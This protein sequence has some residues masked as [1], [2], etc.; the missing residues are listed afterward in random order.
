MIIRPIKETEYQY[1]YDFTQ[2]A[3]STAFVSDGNE[4]DYASAVRASAQYIKE[5]EYVAEEDGR[6]VGDVIFS[7]FKTDVGCNALMLNIV[8]VELGYRNRGLGQSLIQVA[9]AKAI[10][11][12]YEAVF[13]AGSPKFYNRLGFKQTTDFG[14]FNSNNYDDQYIL[15]KE[16]KKDALKD[17]NG[18]F[19]FA[20]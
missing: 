8:C 9:I 6:I 2:K 3:F 5:L 10:E 17:S 16:I 13:V 7:K 19:D 4:Q 18:S 1:M 20:I 12:G 11:L 15:C 14:L